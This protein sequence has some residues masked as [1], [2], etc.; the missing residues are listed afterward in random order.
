MPLKNNSD[1]SKYVFF[2]LH[3]LKHAFIYPNTFFNFLITLL[4]DYFLFSI[5][6]QSRAV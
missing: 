1:Y 3:W 2:H 6:Y 4:S 5:D